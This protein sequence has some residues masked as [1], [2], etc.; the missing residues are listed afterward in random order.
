[1]STLGS[2]TCSSG[3]WGLIPP[4]ARPA[5]WSA[6]SPPTAVEWGKGGRGRGGR[7]GEAK[8][9]KLLFLVTSFNMFRHIWLI[10]PPA[11]LFEMCQLKV[12]VTVSQPGVGL[13]KDRLETSST[14]SLKD[15]RKTDQNLVE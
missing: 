2:L 7:K 14:E 1:M 6:A 9:N 4:N 3:E 11:I 13:N 8:C 10:T 5:M 15:L 12:C